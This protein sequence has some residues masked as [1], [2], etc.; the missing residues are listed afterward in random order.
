ML[1]WSNDKEDNKKGA[2]IC[3]VNAGKTKLIPAHFCRDERRT[4]RIIL[5]YGHSRLIIIDYGHLTTRANG[6][7]IILATSLEGIKLGHMHV[8]HLKAFFT[9]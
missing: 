8:L 5:A 3:G 4:Q 6:M 7:E 9:G 1:T 2:P